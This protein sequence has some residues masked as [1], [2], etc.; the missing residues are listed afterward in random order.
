MDLALYAAFAA[1]ISLLWFLPG[2]DWAFVIGQAS[3]KHPWQAGVLGI[4]LGYVV[5]SGVVAGGLGILIAASPLALSVITI[6]GASYL[7]ALGTL[8]VRRMVV[9]RRLAA[10]P[11]TSP[12]EVVT[13]AHPVTGPIA[14]VGQPR[15]ARASLVAGFAVSALNPKALIFFVALFPQ[16]VSPGAVWPPAVQLAVLGLTW[17]AV[18]SMLYIALSL[19]TRRVFERAPGAAGWVATVAATSMVVMGVV[20][21]VE[22][23]IHAV[24]A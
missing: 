19:A 20:L 15:S 9:D 6:V 1:A 8:A 13:G 4:A 11:V 22:Q 16:F 14:V 10:Q 12:L 17:V 7:I 21:I 23:V 18:S 5:M 2:P 24:T 3:A